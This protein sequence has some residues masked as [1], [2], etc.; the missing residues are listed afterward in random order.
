M[1]RLAGAVL[2][3]PG[4]V[5]TSPA[6]QEDDRAQDAL[7]RAQLYIDAGEAL[8]EIEKALDYNEGLWTAHF[9]KGM[10]LGQMGDESEARPWSPS[11]HAADLSPILQAET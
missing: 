9:L 7:Q 11:S 5:R 1:I 6:L 3:G 8:E 4:A 2:L 10:A